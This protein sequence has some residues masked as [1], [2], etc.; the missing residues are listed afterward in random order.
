MAEIKTKANDGDVMAFLESVE[1]KKRREDGLK[2]YEFFKGITDLTPVLWGNSIVGYGSYHY[3][4]KS[5]QKGDWF[6]VGFSPRKA[7]MTVYIIAGFDDFEEELSRLGKHKI[8]KGCLY[9]NKLE[10][11]D[12]E[13]LKELISKNIDKMTE[14]Y[15]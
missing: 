2:L 11:I 3:E 10:D 5:G 14:M 15:G 4:S 12:L 6:K 7:S 9:I 13:V 8:S 1:H